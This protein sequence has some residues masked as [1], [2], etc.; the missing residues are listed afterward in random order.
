MPR[1]DHEREQKVKRPVSALV[2]RKVE[3]KS[4]PGGAAREDTLTAP[5]Q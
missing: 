1:T 5:P 2:E 3:R 4:A